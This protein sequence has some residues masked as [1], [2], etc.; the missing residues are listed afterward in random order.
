[1]LAE[2]QRNAPPTPLPSE[3]HLAKKGLVL[4]LINSER[5]RAGLDPLI[6]GDNI[7]AQKHADS[8]LANCFASHWGIDGLKPYMRYSLSGGYQSNDEI[9]DGLNYCIRASDGSVPLPGIDSE[10][11]VVVGGWMSN[12]RQQ[13]QILDPWLKRVSIGI[14]W[15]RYNMVM[16]QQFEGD[17]VEYKTLP[18]ISKGVLTL[19]GSAKN[20]VQ[21]GEPQDLAVNIY[22]DPP[23]HALVPGQLARTACSDNGRQVA[24]LRWQ[25]PGGESWAQDHKTKYRSLCPDPYDISNTT[26]PPSSPTEARRLLRLA[27]SDSESP[28]TER[29]IVPWV[30]ASKWQA[31]G[32]NFSIQADISDILAQWGKGVYTVAMSGTIRGVE[33]SISEY[34]IFHGIVPPGHYG[35]ATRER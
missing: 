20:G 7:A 15:D 21:F 11:Q 13:R 28:P 3:A 9:I 25:L 10:I 35:P 33:V 27:E 34:S 32:E 26:S 23:P 2:L 31:I 14:A 30:T 8:A 18:T 19:I 17:Y 29:I 12:F 5:V 6:L 24:S 22:Y 4:E 1:M 16:V